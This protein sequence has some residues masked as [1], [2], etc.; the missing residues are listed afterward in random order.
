MKNPNFWIINHQKAYITAQIPK[1]VQLGI[2]D[3]WEKS[4]ILSIA[5]MIY[6]LVWVEV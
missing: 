5:T 3:Q 1:T 2:L 4:P 6:A